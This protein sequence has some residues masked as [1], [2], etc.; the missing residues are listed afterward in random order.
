MRMYKKSSKKTWNVFLNYWYSD[1]LRHLNWNF[2]SSFCR[3][4]FYHIHFSILCR[5]TPR[6][7]QI[8][9][10]LKTNEK[11]GV[12]TIIMDWNVNNFKAQVTQLPNWDQ[13]DK[14]WVAFSDVQALSRPKCCTPVAP[15]IIVGLCHVNTIYNLGLG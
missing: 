4:T 5:W 6:K 10:V 15:I 7:K 9:L 8:L 3:N 13:P 2:E 12:I 11:L 14:E 1:T